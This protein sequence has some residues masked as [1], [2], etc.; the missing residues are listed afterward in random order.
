MSVC[1][2]VEELKGPWHLYLDLSKVLI[3]QTCIDQGS[4]KKSAAVKRPTQA[5]YSL[6]QNRYMGKGEGKC[7]AGWKKTVPFIWPVGVCHSPGSDVALRLRA[8]VGAAS[9]VL[10][11]GWQ[12]APPRQR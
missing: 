9:L 8:S 1:V 2:F 5:N 3:D 4:V 6:D 7:Q 12:L 11:W 10:T